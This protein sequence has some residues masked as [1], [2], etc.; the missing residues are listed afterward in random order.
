MLDDVLAANERYA[1]DF[2][3]G[4]LDGTPKRALAVLTCMDS[5]L[6]PL[7]MLGLAP[8][9][10]VVLRNAGARI[11]DDVLESVQLSARSLG[12]ARVLVVA[13]R[14]CRAAAAWSDE[15]AADPAERARDGAERVA[16]ATGLE[17]AGVVYDEATGRLTSV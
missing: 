8:G 17:T 1:E 14:D 4:G 10:A 5:R 12:I 3:H 16:A 9:D 6:D 7:P 15:L 11:T 2:A 13:H